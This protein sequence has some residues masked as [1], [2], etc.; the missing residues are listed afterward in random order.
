MG[1]HKNG[2]AKED[3]LFLPTLTLFTG[4]SLYK[5]NSFNLFV[6]I[7]SLYCQL[8]AILHHCYIGG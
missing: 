7:I 1:K 3:T 2:K 6:S 5:N 4:F 8:E